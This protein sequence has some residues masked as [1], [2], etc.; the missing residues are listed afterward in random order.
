MANNIA[1]NTWKIDTPSANPVK[2]VGSGPFNTGATSVYVSAI[3]FSG[4]AAA[5]DKAVITATDAAGNTFTFL[6]LDGDADLTA[7]TTSFGKG[8]WIRNL[9]V[10]TLTSGI[11]TVFLG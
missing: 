9:A 8:V 4:Y 2:S 10:P 7:Q 11:V 1:T 3:E 5:T 6:T